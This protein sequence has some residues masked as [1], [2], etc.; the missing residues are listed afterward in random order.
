MREVA[1]LKAARPG[2]HLP[3][4]RAED[5]SKPTKELSLIARRL[6]PGKRPDRL[7]RCFGCGLFQRRLSTKIVARLCQLSF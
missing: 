5:R 6:A 4:A 1:P 7:F 3:T 2:S